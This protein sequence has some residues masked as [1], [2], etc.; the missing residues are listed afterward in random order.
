[1]VIYLLAEA[2]CQLEPAGSHPAG[3][4]P[5]WARL[6]HI[7]VA[8]RLVDAFQEGSPADSVCI[9]SPGLRSHLV[10]FSPPRPP[11]NTFW[12]REVIRPLG[13][14]RGHRLHLWVGERLESTV[15][16]PILTVL[17]LHPQWGCGGRS[18]MKGKPQDT[19][20]WPRRPSEFHLLRSHG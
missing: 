16:S 5:M 11:H 10:S 18:F 2:G 20:A 6:P 1:M 12:V 7:L 15:E 9:V 14:G 19:G 4:F 8:G 13:S 3:G 17:S